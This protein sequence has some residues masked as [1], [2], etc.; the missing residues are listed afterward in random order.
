MTL[1]KI[2]I[3]FCTHASALSASWVKQAIKWWMP[4]SLHSKHF[5]I[6]VF[7][8]FQQSSI[9]ITLCISGQHLCLLSKLRFYLGRAVILTGS[10]RGPFSPGSPLAPHSPLVPLG[11]L[12]PRS[13]TSPWKKKKKKFERASMTSRKSFTW[14]GK[15]Y[16]GSSRSWK[17][18][19]C[20]A[21]IAL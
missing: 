18:E 14:K 10:P 8:L 19:S 6:R 12:L 2:Y 20:S 21:F 17:A 16:R 3:Y 11:P 13:P 5:Q 7:F 15:P 9:N 4:S 1:F